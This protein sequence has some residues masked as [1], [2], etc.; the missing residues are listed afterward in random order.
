MSSLNRFSVNLLFLM[1]VLLV[2][3]VIFIKKGFSQAIEDEFIVP[4][5]S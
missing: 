2:F 5:K 3:F 4:L 1:I